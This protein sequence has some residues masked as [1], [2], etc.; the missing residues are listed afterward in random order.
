[1]TYKELEKIT[2]LTAR[3]IRFYGDQG[4]ISFEDKQHPG[5]GVGREYEWKNLLELLIIKELAANGVQ[6]S[7]IKKAMRQ[8]NSDHPDAL[9]KATYQDQTVKF[10]LVYPSTKVG[11]FTSRELM[12][13]EL[14][15]NLSDKDAVRAW[16]VSRLTGNTILK[17]EASVVIVDLNQLAEKLL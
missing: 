13:Q 4:L 11:V 6:L 14:M 7:T 10:L 5:R 2:G 17:K 1:M 8:L 15:T 16:R 9:E 12:P 3:K